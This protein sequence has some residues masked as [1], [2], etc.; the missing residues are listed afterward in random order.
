[1]PR[2]PRTHRG[3]TLIELMVVI[4]IIAIL[5]AVLLPNFIHARAQGQATACDDNLK[6]IGS[7][8]LLYSN[9]NG[10]R[11]P[12]ALSQLAPTY[13]AEIP[14]CA[15]VGVDTY[16]SGFVSASNPD[17]FTVVCSGTN[18]AGVGIQANYPQF[19]C[20]EGLLER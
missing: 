19:T 11:F 7:A 8:A 17:S 2:S 10:G 9:D 20:S 3:F 15:S 5:I 14:T 18:H 1:M 12:T 4:A 6:H 13:L 16:T